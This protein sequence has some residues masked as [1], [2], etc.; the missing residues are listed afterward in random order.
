MASTFESNLDSDLAFQDFSIF[1]KPFDKL[2]SKA[3]NKSGL[4]V[5]MAQPAD[6]FRLIHVTTGLSKPLRIHIRPKLWASED[7]SSPVACLTAESI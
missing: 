1:S 6:S 5:Q 3:E 2:R 4:C 7:S